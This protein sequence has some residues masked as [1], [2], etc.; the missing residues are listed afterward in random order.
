MTDFVEKLTNALDDQNRWLV[1]F[2]RITPL[3]AW[4]VQR[5][6]YEDNWRNSV[7]TTNEGYWRAAMEVADRNVAR[8]GS[9]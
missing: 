8:L 5:A 3:E 7:D 6:T 2:R 1:R 4:K 9:V